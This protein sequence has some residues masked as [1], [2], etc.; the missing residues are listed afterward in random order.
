MLSTVRRL[1]GGGKRE[2]ERAPAAADP[3]PPPPAPEP[4]PPPPPPEGF[5][6]VRELLRRLSVEELNRTADEY[7]KQV[8][9]RVANRNLF[10]A[11]PFADLAEMPEVLISFVHVLQGLEARRGM[12]V[13][14]FGAGTCWSSRF[15]T[16][17][18]YRVIAADVS[19]TA[20]ELGREGFRRQPVV[21]DTFEPRFLHFDGF[22][23]DLPD[24]SIDRIMCL[25]AFHHVPN[26]ERVIGEFARV[27]KKGGIAGF[28]EPGPN[29]SKS[30]PAQLEMRHYTV[31]ENDIHVEEIWRWASA[32]GFA[33][34]RLAVWDVNPTLVSLEE[35]GNFLR[36]GAEN[37]AYVESARAFLQ[38]RRLFFLHKQGDRGLPDSRQR[39]GLAAALGVEFGPRCVPAGTPF[40]AAVRIKNTGT[41]LWLP[42]DADI[43]PVF[44]GSHLLDAGGKSQDFSRHA[45]PKGDGGGVRPGEEVA[46]DVVLPV[47]PRP[48]RYRIEFDMVSEYICWFNINGSPTVAVDVE[49]C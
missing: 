19:P 8:A 11:K 49:V 18:G 45:L 24:E 34:M 10:L 28:Q 37:P 33:D 38:E 23:L 2:A 31:V 15:L 12:T 20:L 42:S 39:S 46:L 48:G 27:L 44:L 7:F 41:A 1:L 14:D 3:G 6:D 36:P 26:P 40:R 32:A 29:H 35:F 16:Q 21:G 30:L 13:L 9:T 4:A 5:I 25:S 43:G 47:I 22:R 17:L